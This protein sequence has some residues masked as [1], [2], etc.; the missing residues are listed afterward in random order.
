MFPAK[1][2]LLLDPKAANNRE[3]TLAK[4][5]PNAPL[6]DLAAKLDQAVPD[7]EALRLVMKLMAIPGGSCEEQL[8]MDVIANEARQAGVKP[9]QLRFDN[10]HK[11]SPYGG[12]VGNLILKLPGVKKLG[13]RRM[14]SAHVD[15]VPIC[16][17]CQPKRKGD[18][19]FS[20]KPG[21]ALGADDRAGSAVLLSTLLALK[22]TGAPHPPLTFLWTVQE[23][24]G[25]CGARSVSLA[26]L[27][28]PRVAFNFDGGSPEKV[29]IGATGGY[30]MA[31][32]VTGIASH[33]G[34][35]PEDGVSAISIAALA[36]ADLTENGWHGQIKK[37]GRLGT[38][39]VGVIAG[40]QATN[41]VTDRVILRAEARSHDPE[42]RVRIVEQIEKAFRRAARQVRNAAGDCGAV[43]FEGSLDYESFRLDP[44][45]D[46]V[47]AAVAAAESIGI[48]PQLAIANGGLDA[49]WLSHRGVPTVSFGCGQRGI[50][51]VGEELVISE[52]HTARRL[53][54]RL[55]TGA[56]G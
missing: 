15:T 55:A 26:Q 41:V 5:K 52:F 33:A 56:G 19:V 46:A 4:K 9:E 51:K 31:I 24:V 21:T 27:G 29:T 49:N 50:H 22:R 23:E 47:T 2:L 11:K 3:S 40:G 16:V 45:H 53:A 28:R 13:P 10:A 7:A 37:R 43:A 35:A 12:Q 42:F 54:L 25:L 6:T 30:R 39:N 34:N 48:E 44:K 20:A 17:G 38:S 14:L 8:V 36:I 18:I 1:R 32:E